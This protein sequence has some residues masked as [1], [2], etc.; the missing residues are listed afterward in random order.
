MGAEPAVMSVDAIDEGWARLV[1]EIGELQVPL[2]VLPEGAREGS[3]LTL[4]F[5]LDVVRARAAQERLEADL[6]ALSQEDDG[7]DFEL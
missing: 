1:G 5:Q 6:D 3:L 7:G 4:S 2:S